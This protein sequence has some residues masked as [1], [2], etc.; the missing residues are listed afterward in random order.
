MPATPNKKTNIS[1]N[2]TADDSRGSAC[3]ATLT[4]QRNHSAWLYSLGQAQRVPNGTNKTVLHLQVMVHLYI[5]VSWSQASLTQEAVVQGG[6][7][8]HVNKP[9][10]MH[11]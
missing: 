8:K 5:N 7:H 1:S 4:S 6:I 9:T 10:D 11:I 2:R 3:I